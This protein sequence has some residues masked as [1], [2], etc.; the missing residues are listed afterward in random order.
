M[1]DTSTSTLTAMLA[2]LNARCPKLC[3]AV[4][5]AGLADMHAGVALLNFCPEA[6]RAAFA[7]QLSELRTAAGGRCALSGLET[8]SEA[9]RFVSYW[10]LEPATLGYRLRS[11]SFVRPEVAQL[12]DT[13]GMLERFARAKADRKELSALA[14][15]FCELNGAPDEAARS[16][17]EARL[18]LQECLALAQAC[19]VVASGL[20]RWRALLGGAAAGR[21]C[22]QPGF[23]IALAKRMLGG[24]GG[25]GGGT[26]RANGSA[27][28]K[29][30]AAAEATPSSA[31]PGSGK[32]KKKKDSA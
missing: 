19:Q 15:L 32:R 21:A 24:G 20:G 28:K 26:P 13:A 5:P 14:A 23:A 10:E 22:A 25:G 9:L 30:A 11:C 8:P 1:A 2:D 16:P 18:W 31:A 3:P 12:L 7:A 6:E 17:A 27:K 29:R 4:V